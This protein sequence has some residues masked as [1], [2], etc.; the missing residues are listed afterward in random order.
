MAERW[1]N[2]QMNIDLLSSVE[3]YVLEIQ[4][5]FFYTNWQLRP[6]DNVL[7]THQWEP[8]VTSSSEESRSLTVCTV[9]HPIQIYNPSKV[10]FA[11]LTLSNPLG[12]SRWVIKLSGRKCLDRNTNEVTWVCGCLFYNYN[13][14]Y[15][16][17]QILRFCPLITMEMLTHTNHTQFSCCISRGSSLRCFPRY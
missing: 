14:L 5:F 3:F 4:G 13:K 9:S 11:S 16:R 8:R 10:L 6:I 2:D 7:R 12:F 15:P 17:V 1:M